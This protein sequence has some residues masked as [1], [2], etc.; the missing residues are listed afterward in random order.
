L[1]CMSGSR[2]N[3]WFNKTHVG[4]CRVL[5]RQMIGDG[6][7]VNCVV[8]SP[9]Y[10]AL[11]D[12]GVMGQFGLERTWIRHVA[13]MRGVFRLVRELLADDG[14]LWMNYG[15]CYAGAPGGFQGKNGQRA[16]R[17]FTARIK[18]RKHGNGLKPKDLVGMPWRV[19]LALQDDGW[20]LRS[21]II[22]AKPNPMPES[23]KDRPTKAHEHLFLLS[24]SNKYY[25]DGE[26]IREA[27]SLDSH[28]RVSRAR[29]S[30]YEPLG[31]TA[32]KGI[33]GPRPG[34][35]K[36]VSGW[37]MGD[38][39]HSTVDHARPKKTDDGRKFIGNGVG[40]GH[41]YDE[42]KK[43]R[44]KQNAS[45]SEIVVDVVPDR[46]SRSVWNIPTQPFSGA[47]FASFPEE[48]VARCILAGSRPGDVVFDP[49]M[50]SGTVAQVAT[51]LGR[52]FVGC[53]LNPEYV[54][55]H[56]LRRTTIGMPI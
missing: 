45:F 17:T 19:A 18:Q 8:T 35:H 33:A 32:H 30:G 51:D 39:S 23:I 28:A 24:R 12:Y 9:P 48:L 6:T 43:P 42:V 29:L 54:E 11:R 46:N 3:D 7:R 31:Q 20:W 55:L 4:D 22:W 21:E 34:V 53:E 1:S 40:F 26:A 16:S 49:F 5:M 56:E 25:Y 38:G 2:M 44:V 10:W 14:T 15:D 37:N 13:R 50:G 36:K 52:R 47:H 41:G 27:S